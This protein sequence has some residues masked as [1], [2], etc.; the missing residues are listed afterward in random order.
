MRIQTNALLSVFSRLKQCRKLYVGG[1]PFSTDLVTRLNSI[2]FWRILIRKKKASNTNMR[3]VLC[4]QGRCGITGRP[5]DLDL[6]SM[7]LQYKS[8]IFDYRNFRKTT[9]LTRTA[10][11]YS[12]TEELPLSINLE[13]TIIRKIY[14]RRRITYT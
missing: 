1:V 6:Q 9:A 2:N 8:I 4:L 11:Q 12:Q 10:F 13:A 3:T 5:L 7:L 14:K